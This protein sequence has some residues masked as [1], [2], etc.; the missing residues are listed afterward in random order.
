[1]STRLGESLNRT[2]GEVSEQKAARQP[3]AVSLTPTCWASAARTLTHCQL[4]APLTLQQKQTLEPRGSMLLSNEH[5]VMSVQS[6]SITSWDPTWLIAML[7]S[8]SWVDIEEKCL[9]NAPH[10]FKLV[11][12]KTSLLEAR[13]I[14]RTR[15]INF[16]SEFRTACL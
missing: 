8:R 15:D 5:Q 16:F 12:W 11:T 6:K 4:V 10:I 3:A 2:V 7:L 9:D 14:V 13:N 1:M